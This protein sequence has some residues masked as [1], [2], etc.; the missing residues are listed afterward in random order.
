MAHAPLMCSSSYCDQQ[1]E[2]SSLFPSLKLLEHSHSHQTSTAASEYCRVSWGGCQGVPPLFPDMGNALWLT[3]SN[4]PSK[5]HPPPATPQ[6]LLY[7]LLLPRLLSEGQY[8]QTR[9]AENTQAGLPSAASSGPRGS[10]CI[11]GA[12]CLQLYNPLS[13][14]PLGQAA[15]AASHL[16]HVWPGVGS[17]LSASVHFQ[18]PGETCQ[19]VHEFFHWQPQRTHRFHQLSQS[20]AYEC[21]AC[22]E[23]ERERE[24]A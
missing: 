9:T 18:T 15:P 23:R 19:A 16:Q 24:F 13:L 17:S 3:S 14:Y 4:K 10:I 12:K 8:P 21:D 7:S 11:S 20:P 5:H 2:E 6:L 1:G 22:L